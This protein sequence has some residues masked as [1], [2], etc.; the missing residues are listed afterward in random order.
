[1]KM[2]RTPATVVGPANHNSAALQTKSASPLIAEAI[3][4]IEA[5]GATDAH[6]EAAG[7][8]AAAKGEHT[9][10]DPRQAEIA[11]AAHAAH[12]PAIYISSIMVVLGISLAGVVFV[13]KIIDPDKTAE[14]IR[15]LYLFSLN[16][17]YWDEIYEA[18]FIKGSMLIAKMLAWFDTNIIDGIVNG[19][20]VVVK[21]IA[22]ANNS[23]DKYVV[24]GLVNFTAFSVNTTGAVLRKLQTG[25]VQTYVV[26]LLAVLFGYFVF[27][28]T[29]L[30]Y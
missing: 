3:P 2:I 21:N 12:F 17:W 29:R 26:M 7:E 25:K 10:A 15:P 30:I 19:V 18:T 23:F 14:A 24:D 13:F 8:H 9:F 4:A 28:F 5:H 27:Y 6:A 22:F 1:M 16:K 20:A 11:H